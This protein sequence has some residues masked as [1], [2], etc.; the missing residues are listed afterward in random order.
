[1]KL[2]T[3][4]FNFIR[5]AFRYKWLEYIII[6]LI[7]NKNFG[8]LFTKLPAQHNQ[9]PKPSLRK[10]N[11][12]NLNLKLDI[13]NLNDWYLYF[14]FKDYS[15]QNFYSMIKSNEIVFDI[16]A[17]IGATTLVF[18]KIIQQSGKVFSFEPHPGSFEKLKYHVE[19]NELSNVE[20]YQVGIG[21][22]KSTQEIF[23]VNERN[24]GMNRILLNNKNDYLNGLKI[25]LIT[26]DEFVMSNEIK[27]IGA[28][29]IDVEGFEFEVLKGAKNTLKQFSPKLF[30]EIDS[31]NLKMNNC[32]PRIIF[33]FL[34]NLD[35]ELFYAKSFSKIQLENIKDEQFDIIAVKSK[36]N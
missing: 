8:F 11:L 13:S 9:Y 1:M 6:I 29:K 36:M 14:G 4:M 10:R 35:F 23:T 27:E 22:E 34:E 5:L 25:D 20:I 12:N 30:I 24:S 33:E 19:K 3:K 32:T 2:K 16:G 21:A 28:I 26:I 17:N 31:N 7:E 18:S 15:L